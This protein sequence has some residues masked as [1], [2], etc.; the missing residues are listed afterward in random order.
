MNKYTIIERN[1]ETQR[2]IPFKILRC[3]HLLKPKDIV[4]I[5]G[6]DCE[7]SEVPEEK[8]FQV[9]EAINPL[10]N[11]RVGIVIVEAV[12]ENLC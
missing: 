7:I 10:K 8:T 6:I 12:E 1:G 4:V 2:R 11:Q 5:P 3:P 9:L